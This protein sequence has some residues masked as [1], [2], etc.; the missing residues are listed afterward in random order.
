MTTGW[1]RSGLGPWSEATFELRSRTLVVHRPRHP[2]P[3]VAL[4]LTR[5]VAL[6]AVGP[7]HQGGQEIEVTLDNG[8]VLHAVAPRAFGVQLA[9]ALRATV[10]GP[11][12]YRPA[13]THAPGITPPPYRPAATHAPG[14]TPPP[15][16][17][18]AARTAPTAPTA[19]PA[20]RH[21]PPRPESDSAQAHPER[22]SHR[23]SRR[24]RHPLRTLGVATMVL[25][26]VLTTDLVVLRTRLEQFPASLPVVDDGVRTWLLVG[27]DARAAAQGLPR[28]ETYGTAEQV[29]GERADV[30]LLVQ[31]GTGDQPARVLSVPRDL[32]VFRSGHGVDRLALTLLDGPGALATSICRSL[33]V[34]VDH[35]VTIRFDGIRELIDRVGGIDVHH[36]TP[37]RDLHTG[38][39][40]ASGTSRL[41]GADALAWMRSRH[42]EVLRDG[43]WSSDPSSDTGRQARQREVLEQVSSAMAEGVRNPIAAHRLA[44]SAAGAVRTDDGTGPLDL[45]RLATTLRSARERTSLPHQ[46]LPGRIPVA[47][48]SP[49][50]QAQLDGLRSRVPD[51]PPCPRAQVGPE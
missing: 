36:E 43:V 31:E 22:D 40:L 45:I 38:L 7:V 33:G 47:T 8:A 25:L 51:G 20:Y 15:Y 1:A 39:D 30:V 29:P 50:A 35:L 5:V 24:R 41:D 4:D 23:P 12:P 3:R 49:D 6:D 14:I 16:R 11:P 48:L 32:L 13:A 21:A 19:P 17:P 46:L 37:V 28:P 26:A 2:Q 18:A 44:W 42:V 34:P 9:H 27:T 10:D